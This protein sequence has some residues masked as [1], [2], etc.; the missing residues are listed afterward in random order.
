[1]DESLGDRSVLGQDN[2]FMWVNGG[3]GGRSWR[4]AWGRDSSLGFPAA[5]NVSWRLLCSPGVSG[6]CHGLH[7]VVFWC[8]VGSFMRPRGPP[9]EILG[10][11]ANTVSKILTHDPYGKVTAP[12]WK[13]LGFWPKAC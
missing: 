9:R 7:P 11:W 2:A 4:G 1:M 5:L 3:D 10:H 12:R 8:L 6:V 13:S